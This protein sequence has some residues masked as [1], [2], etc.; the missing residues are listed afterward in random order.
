MVMRKPAAPAARQSVSPSIHAGGRSDY[1]KAC[2]A[3]E[4][5]RC[6]ELKLRRRIRGWCRARGFIGDMI[7]LFRKHKLLARLRRRHAFEDSVFFT[8]K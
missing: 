7:V 2:D 4:K 5:L 3:A 8:R 6:E 1:I